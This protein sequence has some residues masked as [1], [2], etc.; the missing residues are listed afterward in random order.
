M[1]GKD[2][3]SPDPVGDANDTVVNDVATEDSQAEDKNITGDDPEVRDE[4]SGDAESDSSLLVQPLCS[5]LASDNAG[6]ELMQRA[7]T[8]QSDAFS[9]CA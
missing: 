2:E 8:I 1:E 5:L 9:S 6:N 3:K 7:F 4:D